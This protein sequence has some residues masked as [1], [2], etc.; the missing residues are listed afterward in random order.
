MV[1]S[2]ARGVVSV[3]KPYCIS[4]FMTAIS[5]PSTKTLRIYGRIK[6]MSCTCSR[7]V[8]LG[9]VGNPRICR[10]IFVRE[11]WL[12][13][14]KAVSGMFVLKFSGLC[15]EQNKGKNLLS[16]WNSHENVK[17]YTKQP[18]NHGSLSKVTVICLVDL[19]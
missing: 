11:N 13:Q 1:R 6:I 12:F 4:L 18:K 16:I 10:Q 3:T 15:L 9:T 8:M 5:L 14:I 2:S 7:K 17:T 19:A